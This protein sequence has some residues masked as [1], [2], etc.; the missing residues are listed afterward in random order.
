[1]PFLPVPEWRAF[2][3]KRVKEK[4]EGGGCV[5]KVKGATVLFR[6]KS[7]ARDVNHFLGE[8]RVP[9]GD[10]CIKNVIGS[11]AHEAVGEYYTNQKIFLSRGGQYLELK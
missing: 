4:A 2:L 9:V 10:Q 3:K 1:M 11:V 6:K 5:G 8:S 7:G